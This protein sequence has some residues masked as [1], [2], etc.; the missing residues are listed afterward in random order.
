MVFLCGTCSQAFSSS[1]GYENHVTRKHTTKLI[2]RAHRI[3]AR[4]P[5]SA[6]PCGNDIPEYL[7][8]GE[9]A[10]FDLR[11]DSPELDVVSSDSEIVSEE[12]EIAPSCK[13]PWYFDGDIEDRGVHHEQPSRPAFRNREEEWLVN[14][15]RTG[16]KISES[17][18]NSL[19]VALRDPDMDLRKVQFTNAKNVWL[20]ADTAARL[21]DSHLK[22]DWEEAEIV[23][24]GP[25]GRSWANKTVTF[26]HRPILEVL[27]QLFGRPDLDVQLSAKH[28]FDHSGQRIYNEAWSGNR[29]IRIQVGGERQI[30]NVS[31]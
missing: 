23:V 24:Q 7:D 3:A 28:E 20:A 25:S 29:W 17:R 30:R 1:R 26:H 16:D 8:D 19:L 4:R 6:V 9:D 15:L 27:R 31:F 21:H 14:W 22:T 18:I 13:E 5:S 2:L 10:R 12:S 11:A